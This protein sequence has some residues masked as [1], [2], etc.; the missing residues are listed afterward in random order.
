MTILRAKDPCAPHRS[1]LTDWV[2]HRVQGPA[3][4]AA[5]DHL[6]RCRRCETDLTTIAETVFALRRLA[7]R[8]SELEPSA[9]G[10]Q[11]L[12][13]R[14]EAS[15][16]STRPV[17]RSRWSLIGSML[18]SAVVAVLALRVAISAPIGMAR[19]D[20]G[21]AAPPTAMGVPRAMYDAGSVRLTEDIV[22]VLA[23]RAPAGDG[24]ST[25]LAVI[26]S[27]TDRRDI[28]PVIRRAAV[29]SEST[30][31]RSATRS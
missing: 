6:A 22:L 20:D 30:M 2:A 8:V 23:G 21:V 1:A 16:R 10:W 19:A 14:L 31:S 13:V 9:D 12:R 17:G 27:S 24:G 25:R 15:R 26:P 7:D 11:D 18:A 4:P 3:T 5:F 29:R 28:P